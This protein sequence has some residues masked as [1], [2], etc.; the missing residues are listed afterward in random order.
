MSPQHFEVRENGFL[1]KDA[2]LWC[3]PI[4]SCCISATL[5]LDRTGSMQ[6]TKTVKKISSL[7]SAANAFVDMMQTPC[8]EA[9]LVSFNHF[10]TVDIPMSTNKAAL[11]SAINSMN[12]YGNTALWDAAWE[13]IHQAVTT[14]NNRCTAVILLTDGGENSSQKNTYNEVVSLAL[15]NKVKV[16]TIAF[17]LPD[18]SNPM[19]TLRLRNLADITGGQFYFTPVQSDLNSIFRS[20]RD[21]I[22]ESYRE[23]L[24]SYRTT[25]PDGTVRTVELTLKDYCG[26]TVK[27]TRT[28]TAP[29]DRSQ[30]QT[31]RLS[32]GNASAMGTQEV[33]V[34]VMLGTHVDGI[35]SASDFTV[36]YDRTY[37]G[38]V[39]FS[40][41]GTML[42]GDSISMTDVG[43]GHRL[44]IHKSK[45][46][47]GSGIL[48][49]LRFR[50]ADVVYNAETFLRISN[51]NFYGYCLTP[52]FSDGVLK[53]KPREPILECDAIVPDRLEW[54]DE[55][56]DYSPNPFPV[57]V[58][59]RNT[60]TRE[61]TN[62]QASIVVLSPNLSLSAPLVTVQP[63]SPQRLFPGKDGIA[64]W[65]LRALKLETP[66][67][68][69]ICFTVTSDNFPPITCCRMLK[70]Y[71]SQSSALECAVA[72]PDTVYFRDQYYEPEEFE[73]QVT[74][75]NT[76]TGRTKSVIGQ[77]LQ[78]TRFTIIPPSARLMA[79]VL[80]PTE[81]VNSVFRVR[82]HPRQTD[83]YDTVRVNVQGNDTDPSWCMYPIWVQRERVPV[84]TLTCTTP[85]DSLEFSD[86]ASGY[87]PNPF[88]V[89][90]TGKNAGET[91]AEECQIVFVGP[92]RFTPIGTNLRPVGTMRVGDTRTEQWLIRAL[93][94]SVGGWDTLVFQ[95][96][97][98]G[99][100]GK[101]IVLGE[102]RLRV[103]VPAMRTPAYSLACAAPDSL[104]YVNNA[105]APDPFLFTAVITNTGTATGRNISITAAIPSTVFLADGENAVQRIASIAPGDTV[106][107][108]W[109]LKPERRREGEFVEVCGTLVDSIGISTECCRSIFIPREDP[110]LLTLRCASI[111]T[112]F[113][114]A[115]TGNYGGNP[116]TI[117]ATVENS[118]NG[119]GE[120]VRVSIVA[121]GPSVEA[122]DP[123]TKEIGTLAPGG[124]ARVS[125]RF[126]ALARSEAASVPFR[127]NTTSTNHRPLECDVSVFVPPLRSPV[128]LAACESV[129]EDSLLFDW[130]VG[131]FSPT[132]CTVRVRAQNV[133]AYR[134]NTV[135]ALL[136]V[137]PGFALAQ[138]EASE[139]PLQPSTLEPSESG[140]ASWVVRPF[141]QD[142]DAW[143]TF[144]F[145]VRADNADDVDCTDPLFVQGAPRTLV[146][147]LP[148]DM[149][150]GYGEKRPVPVYINRVIGNDLTRYTIAIS[151][152][153]AV[154]SFLH[155]TSIG[156]LTERGWVGPVLRE[157]S[158][159][160]IEVSDYTTS[161]PLRTEDGILVSLHAEGVF[162]R[163]SE[164]GDFRRTDLLFQSDRVLLNWGDIRALTEDGELYVTNDCLQPLASSAA[165]QVEQNI[166]NPFIDATS[167][168]FSCAENGPVRLAVYDMM[169]REARVLFDGPASR[170]TH[171]VRI[172]AGEL[173]PGMYFYRLEST[174]GMD[175]KKMIVR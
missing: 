6:D 69:H 4:D 140:T 97:G 130:S 141:R 171:A 27:Q 124:T 53:I 113:V 51:W 21:A 81:V 156:T 86:A 107:L 39:G 50:L 19:D 131:D 59:V 45:K 67:S 115:S 58:I 17:A 82:M 76:G 144:R 169:G 94:R 48:L 77:L 25:C 162:S 31:V 104:R 95:I 42:E 127:V 173:P 20:I 167:I 3:P 61:A 65:D 147:R 74:A 175:V 116:F 40:T 145:Y 120:Q 157:T 75:R 56:K 43:S 129:P 57:S 13:G 133:G 41:A 11:K 33:V 143:R 161:V 1:V 36:V 138:G 114:D 119:P 38:I 134:A 103:Y 32:L 172:A 16:F 160:L 111:D 52:S 71:P 10:V 8:D 24:L 108:M 92:P 87:T 149:V 96:L 79:E 2:T 155:V 168:T 151:Y 174:S 66:D 150:L 18:K 60:G 62:V 158:P 152:D 49:N 34:P 102:C 118:G 5:V 98:K 136:V 7:K 166:P 91:Y 9:A 90:T 46:I 70:V 117:H 29:L 55:R 72:A 30:F 139:K 170:G 22:K 47:E 121:L 12:A 137:P 148:R 106:R 122:L 26:G 85:D 15:A 54:D 123:Q 125:W 142:A 89:T 154:I 93:P 68:M 63:L 163:G 165:T 14:S 88:I 146:L 132:E 44:Y 164:R 37:A 128:L 105:Y 84:L 78:D 135:R 126:R 100:L 83:G 112:L 35:F 101:R 99:G 73:I 28:Y 109:R 23:C 159:G 153:P 110:P 80:L 64:T